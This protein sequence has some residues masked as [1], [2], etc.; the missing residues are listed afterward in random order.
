MPRS[1]KI[2]LDAMSCY[3]QNIIA[4]TVRA[5]TTKQTS[6]S[7]KSLVLLLHGQRRNYCGPNLGRPQ[8]NSDATHTSSDDPLTVFE[9][10]IRSG[11]YKKDAHQ[12]AVVHALQSLYEKLDSYEPQPPQTAG[13]FS[14]FGAKKASSTVEV[15]KGLYIHG[16][17]GGG[18]TTL[19][20][21]FY[22]CCDMVSEHNVFIATKIF[23]GQ[24][25]P[26]LLFSRL[27]AKSVYISIR[28]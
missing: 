21:L 19:M 20:D 2:I 25:H 9:K 13:L 15:P 7:K 5:A 6:N 26:L 14:W 16:S 4:C 18:K 24:Y 10:R 27:I 3:L 22:D 17:V 23:H 12:T 8:P 11:E 1:T 28:L